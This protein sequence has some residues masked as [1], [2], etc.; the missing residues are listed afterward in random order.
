MS[1][2]CLAYE[3]YWTTLSRN[4]NPVVAKQ[5]ALDNSLV[6]SEKRLKIEKCNARIEF[7]KPQ[8]EETYQVTLDALKLSPCYLAFLITY[9][10]PEELSYSDKCDMLSAIHADQMHQPW[11]TFAAI[12]NKCIS[13]KTTGLDR[14]RESRAQILWGMYNKNNVDYVALL[15]EDIMYQADNR[16]ISLARKEHMPYPRFMK[17]IIGHF[18]SKDT[19]TKKT[20]KKS[21]LETHKLHASG[22]G[23]GVGS[24]PKVPDEQEDKTTGIDA[25]RVPGVPKY[26]F[27]SE[28]ESCKDSDDVDDNDDDNDEVTK[29]DD[30]VD[31]DADGDNEASEKTA[32]DKDDEEEE[33]KEVF[34]RTPGSFDFNDDDDDEEYEELYKDV[35]V[36]LTD[37]KHEEQGK[38]D[39]EMTDVGRDDSTQHTKYEQVKDDE[40]ITLITIHDTQ[41]TE[42]PMQSSPV[43]SDFANRF[44]NLDNVPP[45]DT[46][47]ISM[48]NVKVRHE[49]PSTQTPPLL[50]KPVTKSFRS[51]I[52]KFEKKAKDERK[53]YIDLVQ[54]SVKEI[55]KDE[56]RVNFLRSYQRNV[57]TTPSLCPKLPASLSEI[58]LK[59]ILLEKI[60]NSKIV[61]EVAQEHKRSGQSLHALD[62]TFSILIGLKKQK[63]SKDVEPSRGSKSKE[64]KSSSSKGS[65]SQSKSSGK[66]A[67]AE[68]PVFETAETEMP[69]NQGDD[70]GNTDDQ[71]KVEATS[72]DDWFKKP[73]R[74]PT[75]DSDWNTIKTIDFRPPQT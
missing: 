44:L 49:E 62:R 26:L 45:T 28:N 15:W 63:T 53:I 55:I 30:D 21:K 25:P 14:L 7:S 46:E 59:K 42:G 4:M 36:R 60:Q 18:I 6:P 73:K 50:N 37:T 40:H 39:E 67:Q 58:E 5:V 74:P 29:D 56:A 52:A 54:K 57:L 22:S 9:E 70:M 75:P 61:I 12:I 64:S 51:Y 71:P 19:P 27:E 34:V 66:S 8:R 47:V 24:Q 32:S 10:V 72:K 41:K 68:E 2:T 11:R 1:M 16:E 48:M 69:L 31:S 43:S 38:E 13:G 33:N 23:D 3:L 20:L 17:V 35:N 65:K